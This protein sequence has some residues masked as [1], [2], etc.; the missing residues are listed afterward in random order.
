MANETSPNSPPA[1][2][3]PYGLTPT[4]AS[5]GLPDPQTA[6]NEAD[7]VT[8]PQAN[9]LTSRTSLTDSVS[10]GFGSLRASAGEQAFFAVIRGWTGQ[11][12][13]DL[14]SAHVKNTILETRVGTLRDE[15]TDLRVA[16]SRLK[17][18][19]SS[20]RANKKTL[21]F[22]GLAGSIILSLGFKLVFDKEQTLLATGLML[23]GVVLVLFP[24]FAPSGESK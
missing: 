4:P 9:A 12:E 21:G 16:N 5:V 2:P 14:S 24:I 17:A 3:T 18:E 22:V 13:S 6:G 8:P 1:A 15:V 7:P 11:L 23:L 19:L 20:L 10:I